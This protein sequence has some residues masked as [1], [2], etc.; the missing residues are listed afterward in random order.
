M[1]TRGGREEALRRAEHLVLFVRQLGSEIGREPPESRVSFDVGTIDRAREQERIYDGRADEYDALVDAEDCDGNLI[2]TIEQIAPLRG[3]RV[4]EVGVGTGRITRQL[5]ARGARVT[6]FDRA[7][8][9]LERAR[10]RLA[11]LAPNG[12]SVSCADARDL[13]IEPASFDIAIAGWVFGHFRHWMPDNW[14]AA[15]G[16]ALSELDRGLVD[17]GVAIVVETLGTGSEEPRAPNEALAQYYVWLEASGF[18]RRAIRTDYRFDDVEAAAVRTRPFFGADFAERVGS[19][20]WSRIPECT[21]IWWR[22]KSNT[23][24]E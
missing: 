14:Q 10:R 23:P 9:M 4:L 17:G 15:I 6:G 22:R 2:R 3:A 11:E 8:P 12:W 18:A 21:G 24:R 7:K 1:R 19:E 20:G 5:V 16:Q 13:P